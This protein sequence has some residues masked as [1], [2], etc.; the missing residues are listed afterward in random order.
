MQFVAP[1]GT[2]LSTANVGA[3]DLIDS[4]AGLNGFTGCYNLSPGENDISVDAG[5]VPLA[6]IGDKVFLDTNNN[7]LQ[8]G[9]EAGVPNVTVRLFTCVN[10]LPG[11]Q[12]GAD[13]LT[14]A[15]GNYSFTGLIPGDYIVQFVAPNGTVLS[16]AN[17]GANDLID[18][19]AGLNGFTGC[20]NL[21]PG[22]NDISVDA[23]IVPVNPAPGI[24]II[25][26]VSAPQSS[27][28]TRP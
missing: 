5:I 23:G 7:G 4:D 2:V 3:N 16:M 27:R 8:D 28:P 9:G 15:N 18:S 12:V 14:D 1:N 11:V 13:K 10:N 22:E 6:S 21:S 26:D 24:E 20:Y 25:K 17:V 19:D